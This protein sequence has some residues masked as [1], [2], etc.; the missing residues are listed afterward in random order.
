MLLKVYSQ[1]RLPAR[2]E[3]STGYK[4]G[5]RNV[6]PDKTSCKRA[7]KRDAPNWTCEAIKVKLLDVELFVP[8]WSKSEG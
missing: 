3:A 1:V 5:D 7:Y 2:L 8:D 6:Q 4:M